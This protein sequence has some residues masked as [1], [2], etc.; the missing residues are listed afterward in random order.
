MSLA[1]YDTKGGK[2]K[3]GAKI[4]YINFSNVNLLKK[5]SIVII[6]STR[7]LAQA[8]MMMKRRKL[9]LKRSLCLERNEEKPGQEL[10]NYQLKV[11]KR[12]LINAELADV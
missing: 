8:W 12:E 9:L 6:F 11:N 10:R 7:Q 5:E 1:V 3:F 2:K 4:Y